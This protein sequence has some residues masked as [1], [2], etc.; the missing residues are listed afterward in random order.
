M[1]D[2]KISGYPVYTDDDAGITNIVSSG[3]LTGL[4]PT[5]P[6]D[7]GEVESYASLYG[8]PKPMEALVRGSNNVQPS[9]KKQKKPKRILP[10]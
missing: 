2:K 7:D 5:P 10:M 3:E 1:E 8:T 9:N 4:Q 6:V